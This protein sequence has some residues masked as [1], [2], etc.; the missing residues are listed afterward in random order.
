ME[1]FWEKVCIPIL[2]KDH[3]IAKL[4][5]L[6]LEYQQLKKGRKRRSPCRVLKEEAFGRSLRALF[7]IASVDAL[8][9]IKN[10]A[11]R[12]FLLLL[13]ESQAEGEL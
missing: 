3:S 2:T 11:D 8:S 13:K 9:T 12:D 4:Q 1:E 10:K 7:G 5:K 6:Y